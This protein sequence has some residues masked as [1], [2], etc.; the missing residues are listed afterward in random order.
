MVS[1]SPGKGRKQSGMMYSV[2]GINLKLS[3]FFHQLIIRPHSF[4]R[5]FQSMSGYMR[6]RENLC[7]DQVCITVAQR[8][9]LEVNIF[10]SG[11]FW[12][13]IDLV[14]IKS[15]FYNSFGPESLVS[16]SENQNSLWQVVWLLE[17]GEGMKISHF[18]F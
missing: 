7:Y 3:N 2:W 18:T 9:Y 17:V 8:F 16:E 4:S 11:K 15:V 13:K 10:R 14:K 1:K 5:Y 6:V 12:K